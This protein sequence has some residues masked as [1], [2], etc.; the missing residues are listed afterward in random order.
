MDRCAADEASPLRP[1]ED[2]RAKRKWF[3]RSIRI[4]RRPKKWFVNELTR[5][6]LNDKREG[7]L[8]C[9]TPMNN[10]VW[11]L[12]G[13]LSCCLNPSGDQDAVARAHGSGAQA[14]VASAPVPLS[15]EVPARS[16]RRPAKKAVL[17]SGEQESKEQSRGSTDPHTLHSPISSLPAL[18][19]S[20]LPHQATP[21]R[22]DAA[23]EHLH[24]QLHVLLL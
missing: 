9:V 14:R 24:L 13:L 15:K 10:V 3:A 12:F 2:E 1:V 19:L 6:V 4:L 5:A 18:D 23:P 20:R 11:L 16:P 8:S 7:R 21:R 22:V 17:V